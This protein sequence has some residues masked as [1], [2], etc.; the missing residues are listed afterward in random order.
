DRAVPQP[1]YPP[2]KLAQSSSPSNQSGSTGTGALY[3]NTYE[4]AEL[5]SLLPTARDTRMVASILIGVAST[6]QFIPEF[7]A[8]LHY[9]GLGTHEKVFGGDMLATSVRT[10]ADGFQIAAAYTQDQAGIASRTASHLRRAD[11]W[12]FQANLAARE[13]KSIGRQIIGSLI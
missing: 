2:L 12:T 7:Y 6:L 3:L 1:G 4:D 5:N 10:I 13:L 9:F 8:D 11:D